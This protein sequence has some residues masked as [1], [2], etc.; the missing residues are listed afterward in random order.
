MKSLLTKF[1][2]ATLQ[3]CVFEVFN[4]GLDLLPYLF[5]QRA[6]CQLLFA[7]CYTREL[8]TMNWISLSKYQWVVI[9]LGKII[10]SIL[11]WESRAYHESLI[12]AD[13]W[14]FYSFESMRCSI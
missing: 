10:D 8:E 2:N 4:F 9:Y 7:C 5:D 12:I 11:L 6:G 14:G 13:N 1:C 3:Y